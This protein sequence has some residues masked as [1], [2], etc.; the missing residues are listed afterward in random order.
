MDTSD[1]RSV[2]PSD[3]EV[4]RRLEHQ[5]RRPLVPDVVLPEN[6]VMTSQAAT[7]AVRRKLDLLR[8]PSPVPVPP[9]PRGLRP[10]PDWYSVALFFNL[11]A[12]ARPADYTATS[13]DDASAWLDEGPEPATPPVS[14]FVQ[15]YWRAVSYGHLN[16]GVAVARDAMGQPLVPELPTTDPQ[17]FVRLAMDAL[18]ANPE[19]VWRAAG[20]LVRDGKRWVPSLIV[21]QN[22]DT[23]ASAYF[24]GWEQTIGGTTYLVGDV[25][26]L[27]YGL[28]LATVA[29]TPTTCR[30]F[31]STLTHE[32]GHN[33][34]EFG[35]LYGPEG[36]TGYWDL[37]GDHLA[38]TRMS[39]VCSLFKHR[40]GWLD[41]KGELNGPTLPARE[42]DLRPFTTSSEAYKVTPDPVHTPHEYFLLEYRTSTGHEPWR[43]DG[44]LAHGGLLI[45]HI[46]E[47]LGVAGTWML[48]EAP[49]FDPEFAD[50]SDHGAALWT[51]LDRLEGVLYPQPHN[52]RF[53]P[54]SHPNSNLYGERAS[55]LSITDIRVAGGRCHFTLGIAGDPQVGWH[56]GDRDRAVAGAFSRESGVGGDEL[57][58]RNDGQAALVT[59]RQA[60]YVVVHRHDGQVGDWLLN[61]GDRE[62]V[63]D[64]DGDGHDEIYLRS[65]SAAGVLKMSQGEFHSLVVQHGR[66]GDWA[67]GPD[68]RELTGDLDGDGRDEIYVRSPDWAGVIGF[69]EGRLQLLSIQHDWIDGWNLGTDNTEL[70][71]RFT[72]AD[73]DE[74]LI[75]S[76]E[77]IGVL[78]WRDRRRRLGVASIQHD[79][80]DGWNLSAVDTMI[81]ADLDG[82]GLD[83]VYIRSPHWAGVLKWRDGGFHVLWM[84]Q[85]RIAHL[86][87]TAPELQ[88]ELAPDDLGYPGRFMPDRDGIL[89]RAAH[90][91]AVLTYDGG[92]M[93]VRHLMDSP[94][95]GRWNQDP[96]DRYV[97]G[98][99]QRAG[100]D[101]GDPT[102]DY[103]SDVTAGAFI[104]NAWGTGAIGVNY[105]EFSPTNVLS[106]FGLTWIAQ[107]ELMRGHGVSSAS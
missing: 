80:V 97:V 100:M 77:W 33:F 84:A 3:R 49:Y 54:S 22:Y 8:A 78:T 53:T 34:L 69:R 85:D 105:I 2:P 73:R 38:P 4:L 95:E 87:S 90:R 9:E 6:H 29:G 92:Q 1:T 39:E 52:D 31:W 10:V 61:A 11:R 28:E 68:N 27:R 46:N 99:F 23:G 83:E 44:G 89:H 18:A 57:F 67:L 101:I 25:T 50:F 94:L 96:D 76:P 16:L 64:L 43:P 70:V 91:L 40:V 71:G 37:L 7:E 65:D 21:V 20:S 75:R 104:H 41:W 12:S 79:W 17:D 13:P 74:V 66:I 55:G 86:S 26:H 88:V 82:D 106:Q 19:A 35:D 62:V 81:V 48:R 72:R 36:C 98:R 45:T 103:V 60:Q 102:Q 15:D 107:G 56:V 59:E 5:L 93:R 42:L 51:G 32:F 63:G 14:H 47:R 24:S 30:D 58:L